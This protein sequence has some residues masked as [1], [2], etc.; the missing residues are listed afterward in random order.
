MDRRQLKENFAAL[1]S[2][3]N[4]SCNFSETEFPGNGGY[5]S[6]AASRF[7]CRNRD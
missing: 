3:E 4:S 2:F 5:W 6:V 1:L 7:R